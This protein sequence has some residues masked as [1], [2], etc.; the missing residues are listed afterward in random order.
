MLAV[1]SPIYLTKDGPRVSFHYHFTCIYSSLFTKV[2]DDH[3]TLSHFV[4]A[5]DEGLQTWMCFV[6]SARNDQEQNLEVV[7]MG[8]EIYYKA[9]K[10]SVRKE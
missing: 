8:K 3:G 2:Y 5:S 4:D 9:I 1:T 6:N 7:Q 10:V